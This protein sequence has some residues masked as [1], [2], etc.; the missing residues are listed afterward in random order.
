MK[1]PEIDKADFHITIA[2]TTTGMNGNP[3]KPAGF[4]IRIPRAGS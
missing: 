2:T 1:S 3:P 4:G